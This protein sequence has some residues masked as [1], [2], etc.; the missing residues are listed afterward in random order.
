MAKTHRVTDALSTLLLALIFIG[1]P[2]LL[3]WLMGRR[4]DKHGALFTGPATRGMRIFALL[5]GLVFGALFL[6]Q[7]LSSDSFSLLF[8]ALAIACLAYALGTGRLLRM[9][10]GDTYEAPDEET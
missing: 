6:A 7:L 1:G 5:L 10:Q 8:A 4:A 9:M 2:F 3:I